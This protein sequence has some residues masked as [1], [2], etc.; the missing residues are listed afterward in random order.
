MI[1]G[2]GILR[3]QVGISLVQG[4]RGVIAAA[5]VSDGTYPCAAPLID[6]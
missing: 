4:M 3:F 6:T 5:A 1:S 2:G